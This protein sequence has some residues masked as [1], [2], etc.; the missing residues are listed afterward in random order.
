MP[1]DLRF[2]ARYV[3]MM[4]S[5]DKGTHGFLGAKR[6]LVSLS[7]LMGV[8]PSASSA[9]P[10]AVY[11]PGKLEDPPGTPARFSQGRGRRHT[12]V[13]QRR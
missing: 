12:G 8:S 13:W 11:P 6:H 10:T 5:L 9:L 3:M 4:A 7:S 2:R 1:A